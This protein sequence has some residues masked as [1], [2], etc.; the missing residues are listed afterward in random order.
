MVKNGSNRE[1]K[2]W[3]MIPGKKVA[4]QVNKRVPMR[5]FVNMIC[6]FRG[7]YFWHFKLKTHL[8]IT[9]ITL[10]GLVFLTSEND[11]ISTVK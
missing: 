9:F 8:Y 10:V 11:I 6:R 4:N 2:T 7:K 5:V 3:E 1:F